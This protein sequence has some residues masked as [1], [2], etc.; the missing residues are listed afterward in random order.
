MRE[1]KSPTCEKRLTSLMWRAHCICHR[2]QLL[3]PENERKSIK[4]VQ[5]PS[6]ERYCTGRSRFLWGFR[7]TP[8]LTPNFPVTFTRFH[9]NIQQYHCVNT[10][11]RI[12]QQ[13]K[14]FPIIKSEFYLILWKGQNCSLTISHWMCYKAK[15][16]PCSTPETCR[17]QQQVFK[18]NQWENSFL[19]LPFIALHCVTHL[20]V[21][22]SHHEHRLTYIH[23]WME[24]VC[25]N[26]DFT[27]L[28]KQQS[29]NKYC[30]TQPK[31]FI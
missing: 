6:R 28:G 27:N 21:W 30:T 26:L 18:S 15:C 31:P 24:G 12:L 3:L 5:P 2:H 1:K 13:E 16:L 19:F 25:L 14:S 7:F 23:N 10:Q 17:C 4:R 11:T 20:N 9:N 22:Q 8:K 29:K